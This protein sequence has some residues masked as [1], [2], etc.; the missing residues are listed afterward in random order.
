MHCLAVRMAH[1]WPG[2]LLAADIFTMMASPR[3]RRRSHHDGQAESDQASGSLHPRSAHRHPRG[4]YVSARTITE[5]LGVHYHD[6]G[7]TPGIDDPARTRE[8]CRC[9]DTSSPRPYGPAVRVW[10]R[11]S[12]GLQ[13][14]FLTDSRWVLLLH[15]TSECRLDVVP[16]TQ[17][18]RRSPRLR[19]CRGLSHRFACLSRCAGDA[20]ATARCGRWTPDVQFVSHT[21]ARPRQVSVP[22]MHRTSFVMKA[23]NAQQTRVRAAA[24]RAKHTF[25]PW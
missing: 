1:A 4:P 16:S 13:L 18:P 2:K 17:M 5:R 20:G 22:E 21:W 7:H 15:K 12:A 25:N 10:R 23:I 8:A 6:S 14:G 9:P 11:A 24:R 3:R 19:P